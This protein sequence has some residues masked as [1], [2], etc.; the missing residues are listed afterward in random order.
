MATAIRPDEVTSVL[1][2]ELGG[3]SIDFVG[4]VGEL[5]EGEL[6]KPEF[7]AY[8]AGQQVGSGDNGGIHPELVHRGYASEK[9]GEPGRNRPRWR[10]PRGRAAR[11]GHS[12]RSQ[13]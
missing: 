13:P 2:R 1:K 7:A 9:C 10:G 3:E 12:R 4:Y 8:K 5:T 11:L 6:A